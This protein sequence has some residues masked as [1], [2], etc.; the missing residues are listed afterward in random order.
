M[1]YHV[2]TKQDWE[3]AIAKNVYEHD[4]LAKENFIHACSL[5]QLPGVLD[6]YYQ[7]KTELLLLHIDESKLRSLL[8]YE[9]SPSVNDS[10]PHVYGPINIDAVTETQLL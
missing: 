2:T 4:S 7:N 10:F 6:R 5:Q 9:H 8:K 3:I 1:I